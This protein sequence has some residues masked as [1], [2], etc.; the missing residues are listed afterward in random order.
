MFDGGATPEG[1][2]IALLGGFRVRV[3]GRAI[4]SDAWR[5][6]KPAA[7]VK[8]LAL[9]PGHR[10]HR[11]QAMELLWPELEPTAAAANLRKAVHH[12]RRALGATPGLIA[13]IGESLSLPATGLWV[14][15]DAFHVAALRARRTAE[16][17]DYA[18]ALALYG[19][20]LLPEDRFEEWSIR[21]RDELHAEFLALLAELAGLLE[22]RGELDDAAA[23]LRRLVAA[24][25]LN[26]EGHARL[27]RL[28]SLAGRRT[29]AIRQYEH[30][31]ELLATGLGIEPSPETQRLFEEVRA[32]RAAEPELT[33]EL[34]ERVGDLRVLSGDSAGAVKAFE[35][36]LGVAAPVRPPNAGRLQRKTAAAWLMEHRPDE[37]EPHL[38]RAEELAA[39]A[40]ERGRLTRLRANQLWERGDLDGARSR[41]EEALELARASGTLEDV[42][43]AYEALAVVSHLRGDWRQGLHLELERQSAEQDHTAALTRVFDIHHCIGQYHLYGDGLADDVEEYARR[44]LALA[45]DAGAVRAQAF[46]W[47]LLGESLLLR[48]RWDEAAG[49]LERSCELH[50]SFGT[51]SGALPWQRLGELAVCRGAPED[52]ASFLRRAAGIATVSPM[53]NHLWGRIHATSAFAALEQGDAAAAAQSVRAAAASAARYGDCPTCSALLNP[54]AAET[55]AALEN[56]DGARVH[57]D[58]AARV[59]DVFDSSAWRAMAASAAGSLA[60]A[61]GNAAG[62]RAAFEEAS[63]LYERAGQPYW[64]QRALALAAAV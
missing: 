29:E 42:A 37:A 30:L 20:G 54:V 46:A 36:A 12:A 35:L 38:R 41:A 27:V 31:R 61:E 53:A 34:W 13:S 23:A 60:A 59:A 22:A 7:V 24:D 44:T 58:A 1:L 17:G 63:A 47:C 9:A 56:P 18:A 25:P 15:V 8:L 52:A 64:Q 14:D 16:P 3:D 48:A 33:T 49:C 2:Q 21:P 10:L 40:A 57:A 11:E 45:E 19:D 32:K 51:R 4:P 28:Y 26:E 50:A 62:A 39:D 55:F 6:R 5:R 43:A